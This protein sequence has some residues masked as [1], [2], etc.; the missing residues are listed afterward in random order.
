MW[1]KVFVALSDSSKAQRAIRL[2]HSDH[3]RSAFQH[4]YIFNA[5]FIKDLFV[6]LRELTVS[7]W[8]TVWK[9]LLQVK[10][11]QLVPLDFCAVRSV[12]ETLRGSV[13]SLMVFTWADQSLEGSRADVLFRKWRDVLK[14]SNPNSFFTLINRKHLFMFVL[15]QARV[16][17]PLLLRVQW[18]KA[19]SI[20][21]PV[22]AKFICIIFKDESRTCV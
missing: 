2:S 18:T 20:I 13:L 19:S 6:K 8:A 1:I 10:P 15:P 4:L 7:P 3:K 16:C 21:I 5:F 9:Q 22:K 14:Q 12:I 11:E 17:C